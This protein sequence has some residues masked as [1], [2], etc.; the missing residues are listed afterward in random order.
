VAQRRLR[1]WPLP[2]DSLRSPFGPAYGCYCASLRCAP[3]RVTF[4]LLA[5]LVLRASLQLLLRCATLA[6]AKEKV[7]KE[8]A[9]PTSGAG[10]AQLDSLRSP[11]GP[12]CGCYS[13]TLRFL[14]PAPLYAPPALGL[15]TGLFD[16]VVGPTFDRLWSFQINSRLA[17]MSSQ[18]IRPGTNAPFQQ[19]EHNRCVVG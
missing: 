12:A 16:R 6:R 13:A 19:A 14:A 1:T 2:I 10:Y 8:K 17:V 15:L 9:R 11:F 18:F 3:R 5:A 7:T 4:S